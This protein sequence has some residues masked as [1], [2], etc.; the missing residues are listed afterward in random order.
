MSRVLPA[1]ILLTVI[2]SA[3]IPAEA[4]PPLGC[5]PREGARGNAGANAPIGARATSAR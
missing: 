2:P 5:E 4:L 3:Q 1:F